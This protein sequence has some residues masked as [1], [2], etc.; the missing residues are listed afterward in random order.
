M[1]T[2]LWAGQ[3]VTDS[4]YNIEYIA[5]ARA[6]VRHVRH[7][8]WHSDRSKKNPVNTILLKKKLSFSH[9]TVHIVLWKVYCTRCLAG[10]SD[11][12]IAIPAQLRWTCT[13]KV[14]LRPPPPPTS[15]LTRLDTMKNG[16]WSTEMLSFVWDSF[17]FWTLTLLNRLF[18]DTSS[19][20]P[21]KRPSLAPTLPSWTHQQIR[22]S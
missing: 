20:I 15:P 9:I 11:S 22:D 19:T 18:R 6:R 4:E 5:R 17:S 16:V 12:D 1:K 2:G 7:D 3:L 21:A 8:T 13:W 10:D 14:L